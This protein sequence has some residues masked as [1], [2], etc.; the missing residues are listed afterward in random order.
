MVE[1]EHHQR[2]GVGQDA[3]VD[4]EL[5]AG[6]VD[7]L[8]DRDRVPGGLPASSWNARVE[9]WKSSSVPAMPC[10]KFAASYSG[11]S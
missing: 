11:V 7:A 1:T 4:R 8:E 6:L 9:R 10:R 5:V 3:F 2:V